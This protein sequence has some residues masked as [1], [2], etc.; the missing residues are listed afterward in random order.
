MKFPPEAVTPVSRDLLLRLIQP[1]LRWFVLVFVF[2]CQQSFGQ[3]L[4]APED[5]TPTTNTDVSSM[6]STGGGY[7][8]WTGSARRTVHD[9]AVAGSIGGGGLNFVRTYSSHTSGWSWSYDW[10]MSGLPAG[11]PN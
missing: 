2:L 8:A 1:K 7:D 4:L 9:I 6:I 3:A 11:D 5:A 10:G